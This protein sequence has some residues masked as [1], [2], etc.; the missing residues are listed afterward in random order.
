[1]KQLWTKLGARLDAM[2]LRERVF[3]LIAVVAVMA[4]LSNMLLFEP[5]LKRHKSVTSQLE[6]Q[7]QAIGKAQSDIAA[8]QQENSPNSTSPQRQRI[9]QIRHELAEG[10]AFLQSSRENL[11]QP[12]KMAEYLRSLLNRNSSLQLVAM[13]NLPVTPLLENAKPD[14]EKSAQGGKQKDERKN[15]VYKHGVKLTVRGSYP[16]LQQYLQMLESLPQQVYWARAEMLVVKYPVS[17][18][19]L[20]LYTLGLEKTWLQI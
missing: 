9:N 10:N 17:E 1:M 8:M 18:L 3:V 15:Q 12:E 6:L 2:S 20:I 11:V 7:R 19:T 5:L 14:D 4:A 13:Q 16:E